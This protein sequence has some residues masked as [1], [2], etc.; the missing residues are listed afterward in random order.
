MI[1]RLLPWTHGGRADAQDSSI[2]TLKFAEHPSVSDMTYEETRAG[3]D[4][5]IAT[6]S[7]SRAHRRTRTE[8]QHFCLVLPT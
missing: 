6:N 7:P 3:V 5:A 2:F 4:G 1:L 8:Q